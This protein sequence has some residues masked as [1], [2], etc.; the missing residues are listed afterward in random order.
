[1]RTLNSTPLPTIEGEVRG[2]SGSSHY[3][4]PQIQKLHE[5]YGLPY[6]ATSLEMIFNQSMACGIGIHVVRLDN[7]VWLFGY[8]D[9]ESMF[10]DIEEVS[11]NNLVQHAFIIKGKNWHI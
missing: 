5:K 2:K 8:A 10:F 7:N 9:D 6:Q 4:D 1:M 3:E 11:T